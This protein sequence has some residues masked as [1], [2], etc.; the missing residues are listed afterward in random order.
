MTIIIR[1]GDITTIS[2][3]AVVN[4]ANSLGYMGGGVAG[5]LKRIGG[6][7]IEQEA[8]RHAPIAIGTA[9]ATTAGKLPCQY[10]IHAPTMQQPAM[11]INAANVQKATK[12][13]LD[14]GKKLGVKCI[15]LPGMGTGVGGVA[16]ED[17]AVAMASVVKTF[18]SSFEQIFLIDRNEEM[19]QSFHNALESK[20]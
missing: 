10:V 14:L 4:P 11:R 20:S 8:R 12:A 9:V 13:A 17:A 6:G 19:I 1:L 5:A 16:V 18:E 2:C 3:D 15:A 7:E